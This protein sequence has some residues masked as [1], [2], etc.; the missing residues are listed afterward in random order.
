MVRRLCLEIRHDAREHIAAM[1]QLALAPPV[2]KAGRTFADE[3]R[4]WGVGSGPRWGSDK[5]ARTNMDVSRVPGRV[6]RPLLREQNER[7]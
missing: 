1:N 5:C 3:L 6:Q 4:Q 7:R 2:E